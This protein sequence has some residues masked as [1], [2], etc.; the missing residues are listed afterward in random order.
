MNPAGWRREI[1]KI[2]RF[3]G[4]RPL[5]LLALGVAAGLALFALESAFAYVLQLFL[6]LIGVL[7]GSAIAKPDW[8][9]EL[10]K[11]GIFGAMITVGALKG[12]LSGLQLYMQG[13]CDEEIRH[14]QRQRV[15]RQAFFSESA[16]SSEI[17][18]LFKTR[19]DTAGT[20]VG[21]LQ[22]LVIQLTLA[23]LLGATLFWLSPGLTAMVA[24]TMLSLAFPIRWADHR[25]KRAGE[26]VISESDR[27]M[28]RL[29]M[30]IKNL[31][32]LQIYGTQIE[33]EA[34]AEANLEA[35]R[36]HVLVYYAATGLKA[37]LPPMVG[38]LLICVIAQVSGSG[39]SLSS[40][41]LVSYF[42]LVL[43]FL[44]VFASVN[45]SASALILY[46]PQLRH[47]YQ[48]WQ[49]FES[50]PRPYEPGRSGPAQK[51]LESLVGWELDRLSFHYPGQEFPVLSGLSMVIEPGQ[52][53]V[54]R[55]P[56][57]SGKSTL[58]GLL[59]GGLRPQSGNIR[60]LL[61][62]GEKFA[63]A[64]RRAE[65]LASVGYVGPESFLV[66]GSLRQNLLYG[67]RESPPE[68]ELLEALEKAECGFVH[69]LAQGLDHRITEQ[70][71][72]LSAGQKQ[73]LSLARALLHRP[74]VLILDEATSNLDSETESRVVDTLSRLKAGMTIVAVTHRRE[75]LRIADKEIWVGPPAEPDASG[76]D[77]VKSAQGEAA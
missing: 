29:L 37:A 45:N 35:Y 36:K 3:L 8:I 64:D 5:C 1:P 67:L 21:N 44:Q 38:I 26:G 13:A 74:K 6:A 23:L 62:G 32:L 20:A 76:A 43:R 51:P 69:G 33:E 19:M 52:T 46:G 15:L 30:S 57:G 27:I 7:P 63:L 49:D 41:L 61:E 39:P 9:P 73:R 34:K 47:L 50:S 58:L 48:W 54:I 68:R 40:G 24:L 11:A 60:L 4:P 25:I 56:S 75:L 14:V 71:Q 22:V 31:L 12:A 2:I 18:T 28:D 55:G 42:Y 53:C 17:V 72:G 65:L 77:L 66:E 10:G 16:S 70:G 59:L